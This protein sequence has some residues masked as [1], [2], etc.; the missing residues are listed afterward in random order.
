M[1]RQEE[2]QNKGSM[3]KDEEVRVMQLHIGD[4]R[5]LP[6]A[7]RHEDWGTGHASVSF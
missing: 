5:G 4:Y 1:H 6:G 3:K 7:S 2:T